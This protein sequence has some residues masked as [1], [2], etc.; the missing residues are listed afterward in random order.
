REAF[1]QRWS[2]VFLGFTHC[3]DICPLTMARMQLIQEA[4][5]GA[6]EMVF[7][8]V[9]PGRD[10][11]EIIRQYVENYAPD[12]QGMTGTPDELR[13]FAGAVGA[14]FDVY[15]APDRYTV[16]HSSALFLIGPETDLRGVI[17]PPFDVPLIVQDLKALL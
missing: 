14:S 16:N 17:T 7:I 13:K 12:F 5:N 11:P 4:V 8:S 1:L 3:G 9:D 6:V 2:L 15:E 10:T